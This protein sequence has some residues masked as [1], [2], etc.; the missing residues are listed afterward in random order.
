MHLGIKY[1]SYPNRCGDDHIDQHFYSIKEHCAGKSK[2]NN[3][4]GAWA[5]ET[6]WR[7][8]SDYSNYP[9]R[10]SK[11]LPENSSMENAKNLA[12]NRRVQC[13]R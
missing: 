6:Y 12:V 4:F 9:R 3:P 13:S 7:P 5:A 8:H 1:L 2:T 10:I 11:S